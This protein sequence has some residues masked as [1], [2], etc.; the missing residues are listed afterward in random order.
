MK[1]SILVLI[2]V[3]SV[4]LGV[5]FAATLI[6]CATSTVDVAAVDDVV[7]TTTTLVPTTTIAGTTTTS[8]S[9]L[10]ATTTLAVVTTTT[11]TTT[12]SSTTTTL[13][14]ARGLDLVDD[15]GDILIGAGGDDRAVIY[16]GHAALSGDDSPVWDHELSTSNDFGYG[17]ATASL[18]DFNGDDVPDVIIGAPYADIHDDPSLGE[19]GGKA[20]VYYGVNREVRVLGG[21]GVTLREVGM[22]DVADRVYTA[23]SGSDYLGCSVANVGD[24]DGNGYQDHIVGEFGNEWTDGIELSG[25]AMVIFGSDHIEEEPN[26]IHLY[27][28]GGIG[29]DVGALITSGRFGWSTAGGRDVSGDGQPDVIVGAPWDDV[30]GVDTPL[31]NYSGA[32]YVYFSNGALSGG[33]SA[34]PLGIADADVE[35]RGASG[36]RLGYSVAFA[37]FNGDTRADIIVG[38]TDGSS[39]SLSDFPGGGGAIKGAVYVFYAPEGGFVDRTLLIAE[40]DFDVKICVADDHGANL[41]DFGK[42]IAPIGNFYNTKTSVNCEDIAIG[43]KDY[44]S[45]Q[46]VVMV[47]AGGDFPSGTII[48][49]DK[50]V[51]EPDGYAGDFFTDAGADL[52]TRVLMVHGNGANDRLGCSI[53]AVDFNNN[54]QIDLIIGASGAGAGAEYGPGEVYVISDGTPGVTSDYAASA[55]ADITFSGGSNGDGFG[56]SV[57]GMNPPAE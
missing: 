11:T 23:N 27:G 40:D 56:S 24:I 2:T 37:D 9:L 7:A 12:T 3:V 8:T 13:G 33:P 18:G 47:F 55:I 34:D 20:Y 10:G 48:R 45:E 38:A 39:A 35:I 29:P 42:F 31:T 1:N 50:A 44:G 30:G 57:S 52:R 43:D 51:R 21:G 15:F 6:G 16:L 46:G 32:A 54:G 22:S 36:S 53:S 25:K 19:F 28:R 26:G 49:T 4:L 17:Q 14:E 5:V 41:N